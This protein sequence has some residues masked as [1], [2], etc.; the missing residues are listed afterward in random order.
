MRQGC[1]WSPDLFS[2][3]SENI[4]RNLEK[5]EGVLI[6]GFNLTNLRYADDTVLIADSE[7]KLQKL[8]SILNE[9]S[10]AVGLSINKKKT[11]TLVISKK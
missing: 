6:G 5:E 9:E 11:K 8:V 1:V 2:L 3:Y 4:I 10:E 7:A